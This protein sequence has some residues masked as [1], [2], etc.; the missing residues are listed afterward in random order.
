LAA[1]FGWVVVVDDLVTVL[2]VGEGRGGAT[3]RSR[4][5]G[6]IVGSVVDEFEFWAKARKAHEHRTETMAS[7]LL[8]M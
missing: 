5:V 1:G 3:T 8:I 6:D 7:N 4:V 2:G